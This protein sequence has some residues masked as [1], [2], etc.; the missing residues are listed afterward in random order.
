MREIDIQ[1]TDYTQYAK[2]LP[3]DVVDDVDSDWPPEDEPEED[4]GS[5]E[6]ATDYEIDE[7]NDSEYDDMYEEN[8]K[9]YLEKY[10][11]Q[12]Q[13]LGDECSHDDFPDFRY[14]DYSELHIFTDDM[15][16]TDD[17]GHPVDQEEYVGEIL[18]RT[19]WVEGNDDYLLNKHHVTSEDYWI[20]GIDG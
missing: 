20:R 16:M 3:L 14:E 7:Y 4:E 19:H 8:K 1:K 5:D 15:V 11:E 13:M 18:K 10:G 17:D 9:A 2:H 12:I 6:Y